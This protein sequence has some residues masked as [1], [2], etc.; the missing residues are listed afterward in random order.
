M[1]IM[2]MFTCKVLTSPLNGLTINLFYCTSSSSFHSK[3]SCYSAEHIFYCILI[4]LVYFI[5]TAINITKAF[6]MLDK[7]LFNQGYFGRLNKNY[8]F[9]KT[10]MKLLFPLYFALNSTF[11]L[12]FLFVLAVPLLWATYIFYHRIN[13][14]HSFNS[15]HFYV[16]FSLECFIFIASLL[17]CLSYYIVGKTN[18]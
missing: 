2:A 1:C 3:I 10:V 17:C 16:E 13:S 15:K 4:F 12:D 5:V 18:T 6:I 8:H 11:Q 7:N 9:S 14:F